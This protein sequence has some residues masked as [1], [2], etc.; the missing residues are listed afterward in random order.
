MK[1]K[2]GDKVIFIK[3]SLKEDSWKLNNYEEYIITEHSFNKHYH[4]NYEAYT[5]YYGVKHI[6]GSESSWYDE[7]DFTTIKEY[8]ELKLKKIKR[9]Y[10][11]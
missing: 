4:Y 1:Y 11:N 2:I 7:I 8:R 10:G 9:Y 3:K 6:N 5:N